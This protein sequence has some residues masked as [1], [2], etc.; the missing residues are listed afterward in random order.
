M[1]K[2]RLA[3]TKP[4]VSEM[5]DVE[6]RALADRPFEIAAAGAEEQDVVGSRDRHDRH[7]GPAE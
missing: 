5:D 2:K 4:P 1:P 7:P 6:L 3:M